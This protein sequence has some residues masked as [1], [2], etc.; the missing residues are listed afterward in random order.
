MK[1]TRRRRTVFLLSSILFLASVVYAG[2][3]SKTFTG[4]KAQDPV[5]KNQGPTTYKAEEVTVPPIVHSKIKALEI[6][7]VRLK[8]QGKPSATVEVDVLNKSD[9]ALV[10]LSLSAGPEDETPSITM[11]AWADANRPT[12]GLKPNTVITLRWNLSA[13]TEGYPI[14]ISS[15]IFAD[16]REEGSPFMLSTI[17]SAREKFTRDRAAERARKEG[18]P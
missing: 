5:Q 6:A 12:D 11:D 3:Y 4:M 1:V 17:H 9:Q 8:D 14:V 2:F 10:A 13:I 18:R 7:G 15:A 16:G